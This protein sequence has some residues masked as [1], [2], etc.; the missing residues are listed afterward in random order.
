MT[1]AWRRLLEKFRRE[2]GWLKG[3]LVLAS[4]VALYA[5]F[6]GATDLKLLIQ[7]KRVEV[8]KIQYTIAR[9]EAQC[10][11]IREKVYL[12]PDD[13]VPV[14]VKQMRRLN[15]RAHAARVLLAEAR[16]DLKKLLYAD[17]LMRDSDR[18]G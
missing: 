4:F 14:L 9:L 18:K 13:E 12:H 1:R 3:G 15:V 17:Y 2:W 6:P 7:N 10:G 11:S 8:L 16:D 5:L